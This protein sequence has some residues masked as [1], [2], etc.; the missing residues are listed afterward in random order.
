MYGN[1]PTT[2]LT[3]G[4]VFSGIS[5]SLNVINQLIPIYREVKPVIGNAKN[6]LSVLKDVNTSS[7]NKESSTTSI[8]TKKDISNIENISNN[9]PVFFI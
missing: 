4:K 7:I 6:I 2:G 8:D 3:I 1:L 9:N 5:K